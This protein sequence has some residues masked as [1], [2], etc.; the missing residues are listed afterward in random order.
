MNTEIN[1]KVISIPIDK[2]QEIT[3]CD[4]QFNNTYLWD[5]EH[6][7]EIIKNASGNFKFKF[8]IIDSHKFFLAQ[9]KYGL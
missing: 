9:I 1:S 8:K 2:Y 5:E 3:G 6:G 4:D 7:I